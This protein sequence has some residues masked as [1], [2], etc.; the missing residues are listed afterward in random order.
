MLN[1][2]PNVALGWHA[3]RRA[4][5]LMAIKVVELSRAEPFFLVKTRV[6]LRPRVPRDET[7]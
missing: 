2:A 4:S 3:K 1:T 6:R 7:A 5:S